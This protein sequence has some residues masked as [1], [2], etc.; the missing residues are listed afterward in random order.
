MPGIYN[1]DNAAA[2]GYVE[3]IA[4]GAPTSETMPIAVAAKHAAG[5]PK[6]CGAVR[7]NFFADG[8]ATT[9]GVISS[10]S[11]HQDG[12]VADGTDGI[13][14]YEDSGNVLKVSYF[15]RDNAS[16]IEFGDN[17]VHIADFLTAPAITNQ[18]LGWLS[19]DLDGFDFPNLDGASP[20]AVSGETDRFDEIRAVLGNKVLV[21][22]WSVNPANGVSLDWVVTLP[23]QYTMMDTPEYVLFEVLE[24]PADPLTTCADDVCD[25]RDIPVTASIANWDREEQAPSPDA[26]EPGDLVVSPS[27]PGAPEDPVVT[28]LTKEVNVVTFGDGS[29]LGVS[30][31][32]ITD[33]GVPQPYGWLTLS[34]SSDAAK[35]QSICNW[36]PAADVDTV[37]SGGG[38]ATAAEL[39][40]LSSGCDAVANPGVPMIGFAAWARSVAANPDASYGRIVE[41]SFSS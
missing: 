12:V 5:T 9:R 39:I 27:I 35:T 11:T 16:G 10:E 2:T 23:G 18:E 33:P 37:A 3:I 25:F 20:T 17:A 38:R 32:A 26:P 30:D 29:V 24:S 41:H 15:I 1:V 34:V 6:D 31:I 40:A 36:D 13:N 4:M 22:E 19:G 7:T 21:N 8:T 14:D 28:L